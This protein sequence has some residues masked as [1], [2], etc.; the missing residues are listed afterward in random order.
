MH[1]PPRDGAHP[2]GTL[3]A[4][5]PD[6]LNGA[7]LLIEPAARRNSR[8]TED[9]PLML[10]SVM[11]GRGGATAGAVGVTRTSYSPNAAS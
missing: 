6:A 7:V 1:S 10:A 3:K 9:C 8:S 2:Q 4:G 5:W 11:S